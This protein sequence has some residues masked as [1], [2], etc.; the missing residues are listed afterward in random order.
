M[1]ICVDGRPC[2]HELAA[3][4][5]GRLRAGAQPRPCRSGLRLRA[6]RIES[7]RPPVR[8]A[9]RRCS[10]RCPYRRSAW[11]RGSRQ[12]PMRAIPTATPATSTTLP[13]GLGAVV[14]RDRWGGGRRVAGKRRQEPGREEGGRE[15]FQE[16][17]HSSGRPVGAGVSPWRRIAAAR[18]AWS[19][20]PPAA[21]ATTSPI[22][23]NCRGRRH[24]GWR[25]RGRWRRRRRR[26]R[27]RG[28]RRGVCRA[29]HR[30]R[31]PPSGRRPSRWWSPPA[32]RSSPRRRRG[33]G[34]GAVWRRPELGTRR[35]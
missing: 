32:R 35:R 25:S 21:A 31:P 30:R 14:P 24:R 29:P 27:S 34:A 17:G 1:S 8:G 20:G 15:A 16:A 19:G 23:R 28:P 5:D 22:S 9:P 4:P 7:G 18:A 26:C 13:A 3:V 2:G 6:P 10:G 12:A 33:C 11:R